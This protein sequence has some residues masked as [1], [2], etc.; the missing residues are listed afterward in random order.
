[1][2]PATSTTRTHERREDGRGLGEKAITAGT[3]LRQRPSAPSVPLP[4]PAVRRRPPTAAP[5]ARGTP[6]PRGQR[7]ERGEEAG[8]K[9]ALALESFWARLV[10]APAWWL[11]SLGAAD[12]VWWPGR[13]VESGRRGA[14]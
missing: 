13:P 12:R 10:A 7:L 14:K 8:V 1:V 2:S 6:F 9:L 3:W 4:R 11:G 5:L